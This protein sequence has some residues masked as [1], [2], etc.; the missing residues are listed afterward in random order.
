MQTKVVDSVAPSG[1]GLVINTIKLKGHEQMAI[2][3][4]MLDQASLK[5]DF[6]ISIRFYK[7][8]GVWLSIGHNQKRL[9]KKWLELCMEKKINIVRRPTGGSAVLHSGGLTYSLVWKS[10]PRG[11]LQAYFLANQWLLNFFHDLGFPLHFGNKPQ[12]PLNQNCFD[13][14]TQADLID[15]Y[16]FKRVGSAQFWRGGNLLQHGEII[17][18]PPKEL[19]FKIFKTKAPK[20]A[21]L[22]I[23]RKGL[24]KLLTSS[25]INCWPKISWETKN[26]SEQDLQKTRNCSS[27]YFVSPDSDINPEEIIPST[28]LTNDMPSG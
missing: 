2:D 22:I 8:D 26:I 23:P 13:L 19:W 10:A 15:A 9:P 16:G 11:K 21:P 7:W 5:G 24:D 25:F 27:N 4:M 12:D 14:A 6:S 17:L 28:N 3:T 20:A 1:K 18:D